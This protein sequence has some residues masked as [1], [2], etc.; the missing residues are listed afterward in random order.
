[1]DRS[2]DFW[3]KFFKISIYFQ[4]RGLSCF[5]DKKFSHFQ[6]RLIWVINVERWER[7][8]DYFIITTLK[9]W[10]RLIQHILIIPWKKQCRK[11]Y[12]FQFDLFEKLSPSLK[13]MISVQY[14]ITDGRVKVAASI[15]LRKMIN[16]NG[17]R[18]WIF[19]FASRFCTKLWNSLKFK[20]K[21]V[22]TKSWKEKTGCLRYTSYRC[23]GITIPQR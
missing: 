16:K 10:N 18:W 14:L 11:F 4:I 17:R 20:M 22:L 5:F 6:T 2:S 12:Q 13:R 15:S 9:F 23:Q 19:E 7:T 8:L 3:V 21:I 1:M